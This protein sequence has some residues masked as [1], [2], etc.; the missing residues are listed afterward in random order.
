MDLYFL[1]CPKIYL[2]AMVVEAV[3]QMVMKSGYSMAARVMRYI[4]Q[5]E[6]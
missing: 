6:V 4:S 1:Y 5:A 2:V 3:L